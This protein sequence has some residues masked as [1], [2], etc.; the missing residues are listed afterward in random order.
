M[1][2][3]L[4]C[5][6]S[7]CFPNALS[8]EMKIMAENN[9]LLKCPL[10][11]GQGEVRRAELVARLSEAELKPKLDDLAEIQQPFEAAEFAGVAAHGQRDF[12]KDVHSWNP[13]LPMW[14][15]SPKE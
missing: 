9:D 2:Y 5:G 8:E 1:A 4:A 14:R 13:Q 6:L 12:Q 11:E 15:R 7:K 3:G 10:C